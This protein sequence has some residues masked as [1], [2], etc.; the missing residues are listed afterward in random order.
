MSCE[1]KTPAAVTVC[2]NGSLLIH[3]TVSPRFTVIVS[4]S[5]LTPSMTTVC[6]AGVAAAIAPAPAWS[7]PHAQTSATAS[8]W[9]RSCPPRCP[10]RALMRRSL[11]VDG[12][13]LAKRRLDLF[14]VLEVPHEG[15]PHL[16]DQ[17]LQLFVLGTG[18]ERLVDRVEHLLMVSDFVVDVGLVEFGALQGLEVFDVFL[19][20]GLEALAG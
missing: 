10:D 9:L 13:L 11:A 3:V 6:R 14:G 18:D 8:R 12:V 7:N 17:C 1:S 2:G 5:N 20:A 16:H 4:G 15:R 19:A